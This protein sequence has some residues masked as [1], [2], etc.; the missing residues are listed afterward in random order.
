MSSKDFRSNLKYHL[1]KNIA[2]F[3]HVPRKFEKYYWKH[4]IHERVKSCVKGG[5]GGVSDDEIQQLFNMIDK[6]K[7]GTLSLRVFMEILMLKKTFKHNNAQQN[8]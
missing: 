7:S 3:K 6:D 5:A 4:G 8:I 1:L 2:Q